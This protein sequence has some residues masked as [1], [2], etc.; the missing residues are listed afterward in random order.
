MFRTVLIAATLAG[1]IGAPPAMAQGDAE[2]GETVFN[3][4]CR[5]CHQVGEGARNTAGPALTGVLDR[6]I[7]STEGFRYS[8]AFTAK[9]EEGFVWTEEALTEYLANPRAYIPGNRMAFAGLRSDEDIANMIAYLA[10]FE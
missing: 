4:Q 10:T 2:A 5:A 7:A 6:E 1:G 9:K 3:R 8:P